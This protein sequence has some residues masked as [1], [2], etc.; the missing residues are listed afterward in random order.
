[1]S[2][3]ALYPEKDFYCSVD[4]RS[5][6]LGQICWAPTP[7]P[8]PIPKILDVER[9]SPEEH[10][11]VRFVLRDAN[12]PGDFKQRDRSLP[13]KY[14]NL[15]SHE[16]LLIQRAKKRPVVIVGNGLDCYTQFEHLL[17]QKGKRHLQEDSVFVAPVY[18]VCRD[19]YGDGFVKEMMPF[20]EC[21]LFRQFFYIPKSTI[22]KEGVIRL[23]R[24]Q[25]IIDRGPASLEPSDICLSE[26]ILNI[27][28]DTMTYCLTG[29]ASAELSELRDL[30]ASTIEDN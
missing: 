15:K 10:E 23:D 28:R 13:V 19:E 3:T 26:P 6:C 29:I 4:P 27:L 5:F 8:T 22:F 14:L 20:I 9:S 11:R 7:M 18:T 25:V 24:L 12:R 21:L 1:M 2:L 30:L 17:R 16:E